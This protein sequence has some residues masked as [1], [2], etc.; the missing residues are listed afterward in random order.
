MS[1]NIQ[2]LISSTMQQVI[3]RTLPSCHGGTVSRELIQTINDAETIQ[4]VVG[5]VAIF[6]MMNEAIALAES[7]VLIQTFAY[8]SDI[9]AVAHLHDT[10]EQIA[11]KKEEQRQLG[12]N[13]QP[14]RVYLLID[15]RGPLAELAFTGRRS[16]SWP[17]TP[18]A[19]GLVH[20]PGLVE[21]YVDVH[22]HNSL[23]GNHAKTMVIDSKTFMITGANF[24]S[25][26]Y[27]HIPAHDAGWLMNGEA[28]RSAREDFA[29]VWADRKNKLNTPE[30][31]PIISEPSQLPL[32]RP[33]T[34]LFATRSAQ[35]LRSTSSLD[36][37]QNCAF[38][39]GINAA[40]RIVRIA[41][42]NL[43]AQFIMG[44]L[45]QFV[46]QRNGRVQLLLGKGFND[47]RE[48]TLTMGGSN[49]A[50]V[51]TLFRGIF[52]DKVDHL[53]IR[54]FSLNGRDPV[55]GNV[56]GACHL[57][58]MNIDDQLAIVGNAN[59]DVISTEHLHEANL[60]IDDAETTQRITSLVFEEVFSRGVRAEPSENRKESFLEGIGY[61]GWRES[62]GARSTVNIEE[63]ILE[64]E[65]Y[66][67]IKLSRPNNF[68]F[69]PGQY[70]EIRS[71]GVLSKAANKNPAVLAIASGSAEGILEVTGRGSGKPWHSNHILNKN[72]GATMEITGPLGTSFPM[73]LVTPETPLYLLGGGSGLTVIRSLHR[74][75]PEGITSTIYYSAQ[76]EDSLFYRDD[77]DRWR[78]EGHYISLTQEEKEGFENRRITDK[79]QEQKIPPE[80]LA[81]ICGPIPLIQATV[82]ALLNQG[83]SNKQ[84]FV[85]LPF[86]AKQRGPVYRADD[87]KIAR[88]NR[89]REPSTAAASSSSNS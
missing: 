20:R 36:N 27:G 7:E 18:G 41:T 19:V 2:S 32:T 44:S 76:K 24:Q 60:V 1:A 17:V 16:Q 77:I 69:Q 74:S 80:S 51:D 45:V 83:L 38:S 26:N 75:L 61:R 64:N 11:A 28:A 68:S 58:F 65:G 78:S 37:P 73:E 35:S 12:G 9:P 88:W 56:A 55:I 53:D 13:V 31:F 82:R 25:S 59:L 6:R 49:Q 47:R 66:K 30:L 43:N 57:K 85:S 42:P 3:D 54:W 63:V 52:P 67:T 87:P 10:L 79:I 89:L 23:A 21:V 4:T 71:G 48:A 22:F 15:E 5:G 50:A 86:G 29:A 33:V 14:L 40:E 62:L 8:E 84:I 46:N 70:L 39:S 72:P 81:F 34:I